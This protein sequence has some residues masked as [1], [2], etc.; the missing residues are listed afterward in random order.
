MFL[1]LKYSPKFERERKNALAKYY[2]TIFYV[3]LMAHYMLF[4]IHFINLGKIRRK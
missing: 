2:T 3:T 4:N 1:S